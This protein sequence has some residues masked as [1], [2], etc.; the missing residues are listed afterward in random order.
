M[1]AK[2]EARIRKQL[3]MQHPDEDLIAAWGREIQVWKG[4]V[5]RLTRRLKREW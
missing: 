3:M 2:H 5:S 4:S 1:I